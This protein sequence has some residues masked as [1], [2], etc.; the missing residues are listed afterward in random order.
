MLS[1]DLS[2]LS[3]TTFRKF[4]DPSLL[5]VTRPGNLACRKANQQ[6][7]FQKYFCQPVQRFRKAPPHRTPPAAQQTRCFALR[8]VLE[9]DLC[10]QFIFE[11][12]QLRQTGRHIVDGH[13]RIFKGPGVVRSYPGPEKLPAQQRR[14]SP[15]FH[16]QPLI[17]SRHLLR[18]HR[19]LAYCGPVRH[20]SGGQSRRTPSNNLTASSRVANSSRV[21]P[22]RWLARYSI[23]RRR[24]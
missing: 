17:A 24:P 23:L 9:C 2:P 7:R 21:S 4:S 22:P 12:T 14:Q 10:N 18:G 16:R 6:P 8:V 11:S 19:D 20:F 5:T 1:Q 15:H 3:R 13:H